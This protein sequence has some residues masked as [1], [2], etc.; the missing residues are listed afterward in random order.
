MAR[1]HDAH[2]TG[3]HVAQEARRA[4]T[5]RADDHA[6]ATGE[7]VDTFRQVAPQMTLLELRT[8]TF[9][10]PQPVSVNDLYGTNL[11]TGQKFLVTA[12]KQFRSQ[13]ISI[14]H[15]EMLRAEQRDQPLLGKL[16]A[17]V[18]VSDLLDIDNG[19]KSLFDGLQHAHAY[20]NDRQIKRLVVDCIAMPHGREW[21]D[22]T[23][24]EIGA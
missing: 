20:A 10:L 23:L 16:E 18:V 1:R 3:I 7:V 9:R 5:A 8:L 24:T 13:V 2:F 19:L 12:Q 4:G 11:T 22:V 21:C 15:G 6:Y 17:R 14:V